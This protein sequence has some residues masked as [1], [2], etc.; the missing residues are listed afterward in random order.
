MKQKKT[1]IINDISG[2]GKMLCDGS[3]SDH[4]KIKGAV[5]C[6]PD[7]DPIQSYRV[8]DVLF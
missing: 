7:G 5:L 1:V 2:F 8:S 4:F 3:A 6:G